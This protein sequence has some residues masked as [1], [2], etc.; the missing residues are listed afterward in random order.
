MMG[1][2][3]LDRGAKRKILPPNAQ[4]AEKTTLKGLLCYPSALPPKGTGAVRA[5]VHPKLKMH[6]MRFAS[7]LARVKVL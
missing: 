4:P 1:W 6:P 2:V 3:P 7:L 5:K